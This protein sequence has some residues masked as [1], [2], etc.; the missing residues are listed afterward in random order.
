MEQKYEYTNIFLWNIQ[1]MKSISIPACVG[2]FVAVLEPWHLIDGAAAAEE[3]I[4]GLSFAAVATFKA[5][6][7][8]LLSTQLSL[9]FSWLID[10]ETMFN[11]DSDAYLLLN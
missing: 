10:L 6:F 2:L 11:Y 5:F 4:S 9:H 1:F 3:I 8:A 7:V